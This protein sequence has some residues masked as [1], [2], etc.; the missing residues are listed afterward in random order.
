MSKRTK[1]VLISVAAIL[2]LAIIGGLLY[3][4]LGYLP[5]KRKKEEMIQM[6]KE[7]YNQKLVL[8]AEEN[9][10]YADYEVD[11][12]FIGDS[13]T[14]GYDVERYYPEYKVENRGIGGDRITD[15]LGRMGK[16][17][18]TVK[19]DVMSILI[20]VNDVWHSFD[21]HNG[22]RAELYEQLYQLLITE[23]KKELPNLQIIILEPF[24]LKG[25]ATEANWD[26]FRAEVELRAAAARRIAEAN[27]L[28]FVPLQSLFDAAQEQYP[29]CE[30]LL[31]GVHPSTIGHELIA[32]EWI[33]AFS[34]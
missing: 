19:P 1:I 13:L 14:D 24:V 27:G 32:R 15:L 6:A 30:W 21:L 23:V 28:K 10:K 18:L 12:A 31:D 5:E 25:T 22:V 8:Y 34:E 20:G 29:D 17:I 16:D 9:E 4:F 33:K 3:L 7:Y 26:A 11:I 2:L